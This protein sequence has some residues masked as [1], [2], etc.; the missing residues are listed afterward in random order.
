MSERPPADGLDVPRLLLALL[1]CQA[2]GGLGA[3]AT[4]RSVR[5][6]YVGLRK[7]PLNPPPGCVFST[8]CAH[9]I[10]VSPGTR[11]R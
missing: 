6:W 4:A 9:A 1:V 11:P 8:R 2:A 3:I 5:T 7:S 10:A